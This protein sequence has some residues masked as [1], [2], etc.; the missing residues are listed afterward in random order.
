M[1]GTRLKAVNGN[2][3]TKLGVAVVEAAGKGLVRDDD[4]EEGG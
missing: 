4:D 3:R 2:R 1:I